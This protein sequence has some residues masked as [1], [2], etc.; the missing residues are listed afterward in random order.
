MND[1]LVSGSPGTTE[2]MLSGGRCAECQYFCIPMLA[3]CAV[4]MSQDIAADSVSGIGT[5]YS[6]TVV[7]NG[8]RDRALPYGLAFVDLDEG[9]R[10]MASYSVDDSGA[11]DP[12]TRVRVNQR[13]LSD[14]GLPLLTVETLQSPA[15]S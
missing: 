1:V 5:L 2:A 9:I 3:T 8:P 7:R 12:D 15:S 13:G 10:V 14:A 4:C 11:L 6:A